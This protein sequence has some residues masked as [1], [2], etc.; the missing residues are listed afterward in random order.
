M[1]VNTNV[2]VLCSDS[3]LRDEMEAAL[4]SLSQYRAT[5]YFAANLHEAIKAIRNR[6]PRLVVV[7]IEPELSDVKS[8]ADELSAIAPGTSLAG[9][10]LPDVYST[11]TSESA[12]LL[13]AVR[14]G[15]KDFLRRPVSSTE[16]GELLGRA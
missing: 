7:E 16:L 6:R 12:L 3:R 14:R 5:G 13:A 10:I 9:A 2:V 15:V 11:V 4:G 8:L 1:T